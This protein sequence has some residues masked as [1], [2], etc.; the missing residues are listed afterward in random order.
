MMSFYPNPNVKT[1]RIALVIYLILSHE[2]PDKY[3]HIQ[4]ESTAPTDL[5]DQTKQI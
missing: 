2:I 5:I 1:Q 3:E 4:K